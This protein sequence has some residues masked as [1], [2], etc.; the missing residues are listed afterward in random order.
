V[1]GI[2]PRE[3]FSA[4]VD[5]R[6]RMPI[7][8]FTL[9]VLPHFSR[10]TPGDPALDGFITFTDL[11]PGREDAMLREQIDHFDGLG[12]GFEW[13]VYEFDRPADLQARLARERFVAGPIEAFMVFPLAGAG[14]AR[15]APPGIRIERITTHAGV[16]DFV[17]VDQEVWGKPKPW[18]EPV[19]MS[20]L[21]ERP[22]EIAIFCA[23]DGDR[24]IGTGLVDLPP[25]GR[26]ADLHAGAVVE[27]HRGHGIYSALF[28]IR[29]EEARRRGYRHLA[30][31]AA[32]M[33][34]PILLRMGFEHVCMTVPMR[35]ARPSAPPA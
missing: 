12:R 20:R 22:D 2:D 23:Y 32:P 17:R 11:P 21:R 35:R 16:L 4:Y 24:P 26:F 27:S 29:R 3:V 13:K 8:G 33:S 1:S 7:P 14:A 25:D 9:D 6:R 18:I 34:R 31:D 30:V 19:M 15:E 5:E 10:Y 28:G